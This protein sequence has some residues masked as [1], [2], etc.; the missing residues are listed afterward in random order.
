MSVLN[1]TC[2]SQAKENISSPIFKK[3]EKTPGNSNIWN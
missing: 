3:D 2:V 1:V